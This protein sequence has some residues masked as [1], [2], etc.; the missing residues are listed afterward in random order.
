[1]LALAV[2]VRK[3]LAISYHLQDNLRHFERAL[4]PF[5]CLSFGLKLKPNTLLLKKPRTTQES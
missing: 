1:V 4:Q 2:R 3:F 5:S